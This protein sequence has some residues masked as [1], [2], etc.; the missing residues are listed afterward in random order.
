[1]V[2][3]VC[4]GVSVVDV[5]IVCFVTDAI[6]YVIAAAAVAVAVFLSCYCR[7]T[8]FSVLDVITVSIVVGTAVLLL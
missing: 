2:F 3:F 8:V 4:A 6:D 1:M 7:D 5:D